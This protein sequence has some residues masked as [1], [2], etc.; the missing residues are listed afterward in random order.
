MQRRRKRSISED[1]RPPG[2]L[3]TV[4][5]QASEELGVRF[6]IGKAVAHHLY[7]HEK[8]DIDQSHI[9]ICLVQAIESQDRKLFLEAVD[10]KRYNGVKI[11][12]QD[13]EN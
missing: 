11:F 2:N 10:P 5:D 13:R 4:D 3:A 9:M 12:V 1:R 6:A 8:I 7:I